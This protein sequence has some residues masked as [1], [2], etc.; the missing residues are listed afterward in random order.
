MMIMNNAIRIGHFTN[1][2]RSG[3]VTHTV[4]IVRGAKMLAKAEAPTFKQ[5]LKAARAGR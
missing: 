4:F 5:A 1:N 2:Y 3:R